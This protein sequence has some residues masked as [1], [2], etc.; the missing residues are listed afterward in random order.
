MK[1][2]RHLPVRAIKHLML[3][4]LATAMVPISGLGRAEATDTLTLLN[5]PGAGSSVTCGWHVV[6]DY[7]YTAGPGLDWGSSSG[8]SVQW[9]SYG[10]HSGAPG[11]AQI[12]TATI[13]DQSSTC[14]RANIVLRNNMG[15]ALGSVLY[16]H[17]Q[18]GSG[19]FGINGI[20]GG[21]GTWTAQQIGTTA[22]YLTE[23]SMGCTTFGDHLHQESSLSKN[24]NYPN[25][26]STT[27]CT[28][29]DAACWQ[30]TV[31]WFE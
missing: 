22:S 8:N 14:Y 1:L 6:C 5:H 7:P 19:T 12:A 28:P 23:Q 13:N 15:G 31:Q 25:A 18:P 29:S 20:S 2:G 26:P 30:H 3:A 17:T 4:V 16:V 24:T 9:R 11:G 27:S 21:T 10:H